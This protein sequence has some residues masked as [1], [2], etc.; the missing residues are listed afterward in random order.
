MNTDLTT[1]LQDAGDFYI[2]FNKM[3]IGLRG[4]RKDLSRTFAQQKMAAA[5]QVRSDYTR[6]FDASLSNTSI[7][8]MTAATGL[9]QEQLFNE[10]N[11]ELKNKLQKELKMQQ[12]KKMLKNYLKLQKLL[13]KL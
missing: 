4:N 1:A 10:I 2:H 6:Y 13:V 9:S 11:N 12:K 3:N 8:A 5:A 7:E